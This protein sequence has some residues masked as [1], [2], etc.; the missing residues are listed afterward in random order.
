[1]GFWIVERKK[2]N[3]DVYESMITIFEP[4]LTRFKDEIFMAVTSASTFRAFRNCPLNFPPNS[5]TLQ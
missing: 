4:L 3:G 5:S 1:M 2:R